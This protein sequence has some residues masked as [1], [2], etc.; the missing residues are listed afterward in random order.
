MA[1]GNP[2]HSPTSVQISQNH[3]G[4]RPTSRRM[5]GI[6]A[7]A[8][9]TTILGRATYHRKSADKTIPNQQRDPESP[10]IAHLRRVVDTARLPRRTAR[11]PRCDALLTQ[12]LLITNGPT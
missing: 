6:P 11:P 5:R 12:C 8:C 7:A 3:I 4:D 1:G 9:G 10:C 2:F